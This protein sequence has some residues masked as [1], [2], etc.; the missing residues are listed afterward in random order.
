MKQT[1]STTMTMTMTDKNPFDLMA[2]SATHHIPT[3]W[4]VFKATKAG[5]WYIVADPQGIAWGEGHTVEDATYDWELAARE[6]L[7]LLMTKEIHPTL[8]VRRDTLNKWFP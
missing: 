2:D 3:K 1:I 6:I 4:G 5:D 8:E 7:H